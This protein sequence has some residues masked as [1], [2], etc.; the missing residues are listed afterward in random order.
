[1]KN[2]YTKPTPTAC[3]SSFY[4]S[5]WE[6]MLYA[7]F[8]FDYHNTNKC[9]CQWFEKNIVETVV[10][11]ISVL[12]SNA[13]VLRS[14]FLPFSFRKRNSQWQAMRLWPQT[15]KMRRYRKSVSTH[16]CLLGTPSPNPFDQ[17]F[18]MLAARRNGAFYLADAREF[19]RTDRI[20]VRRISENM[21][22]LKPHEQTVVSTLDT[23]KSK[24]QIKDF[25]AIMKQ[26]PRREKS[27]HDR[28]AYPYDGRI[29]AC[30]RGYE[31][32]PRGHLEFFIASL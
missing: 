2:G 20:T 23:T 8:S 24:L 30:V 26:K 17:H 3:R 22:V 4:V 11:L 32:R 13:F 16:F 21:L 5:A 29:A 6:N 18:A 14:A 27:D 31:Q 10:E 7:I 1:M 25:F 19:W 28:Q 12:A 9:S 15:R